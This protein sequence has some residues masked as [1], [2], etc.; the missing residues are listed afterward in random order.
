MRTKENE[1]RLMRWLQL[2]AVTYLQESFKELQG[3]VTFDPLQGYRFVE[4]WLV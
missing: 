3:L 4:G 1:G 2:T